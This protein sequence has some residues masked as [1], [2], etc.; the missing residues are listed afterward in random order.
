[1]MIRPLNTFCAAIVL[2]LVA[3]PAMAQPLS[4]DRIERF[5]ASLEDLESLGEQVENTDMFGDMGQE[6]Q[7]QAMRKGEFRPMRMMVEKMRDHEMHDEF[8]AAVSD[9]GFQRPEDWADTGDRI[10]RAMAAMELKKHNRGDM[11]AE[12]GAMM[13]QMENNPNISEQQRKRMRQQME[14]AMAGMKAMA[15]A[16]EEDIE[17]VRPYRDRIRGA[18]ND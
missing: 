5:L 1:M 6:I 12:M 4:D 7:E 14:Q 10:M 15:D 18:M 17:A 11:Q 8:A 3:L 13:E 2:L 9:H 16:P